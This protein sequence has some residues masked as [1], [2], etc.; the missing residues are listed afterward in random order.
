MFAAVMTDRLFRIPSYRVADNRQ[1]AP[2][3]TYVYELG[4]RTPAAI[5]S[6]LPIGAGH[7]VDLPF[8]WDTLAAPG[9]D[10]LLGSKP[11]AALAQKIHARWI[12]FARTGELA[13][14]P[15]YDSVRPVMTFA[16]DNTATSTIDNDPRS[17]ERQLW[18]GT[19][20]STGG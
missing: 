20:F 2:T 16:K 8:V 19:E 4:W 12:E 11:P 1:D 9:A 7:I 13:D 5:G 15:A 3:P 17:K 6:T 10:Q 14:W 18:D